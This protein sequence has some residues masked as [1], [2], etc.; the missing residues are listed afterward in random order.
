MSS[1]DVSDELSPLPTW[2]YIELGMHLWYLHAADGRRSLEVC[3]EIEQLL[4]SL[5]RCR[6]TITRRSSSQIAD[7]RL[8]IDRLLSNNPARYENLPQSDVNILRSVATSVKNQLSVEASDKRSIVLRDSPIRK[9]VEERWPDLDDTQK[10]LAD[11]TVRCME[12][13]SYRAA[14]V[15]GWNLT[16]E[17][18]R[19]WTFDA[20]DRHDKFNKWLSGQNKKEVGRYEDF[21]HM[22]ERAFLD[23]LKGSELI[24]GRKYDE[25]KQFLRTRNEY[26]HPN[27]LMATREKAVAYVQNLLDIITNPPF[28][29][30]QQPI[31]S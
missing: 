10:L 22:S 9:L 13:G 14:M 17:V 31:R 27:F 7:L 4:T 16:Y 11:E 18:I 23:A 20:N 6:M 24:G 29:S 3:H 5:E 28:K 1:V 21:F 8:Q 30:T 19:H 15:M 26:A 12:S 2:E 25:L